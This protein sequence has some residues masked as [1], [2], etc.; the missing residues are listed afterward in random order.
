MQAFCTYTHTH[1]MVRDMKNFQEKY[2]YGNEGKII[3]VSNTNMR[4]NVT[5]KEK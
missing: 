5:R 2:K 4:T 3:F 1:T